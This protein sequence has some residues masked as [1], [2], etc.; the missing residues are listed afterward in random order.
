MPSLE[1]TLASANAEL[2]LLLDINRAIGR[3]LSRDELFGSLADRL[4]TI[5]PTDRFGIE[6]PIEGGK[7]QGHLLSRMPTNGEPTEP[8]V[9]PSTG[10]A[11]DWVI[12]N[13][14]WFVAD[15]RDELRDRFPITFDVMTSERMESLC[16]LPLISGGRALGAL[17]FMAASKSAYRHLR[18]EFLDQVSNQMAIAVE[19]MKSYEEIAALNRTIADGAARLRTILEINNAI[20]TKLTRDEVFRAI[21]AALAPLVPYDRIAL[22]LYDTATNSVCLVAYEGPLRTGYS[23]VGNVHDLD[24]SHVGWV[25]KEKRPLLR[26]DLEKEQQF[27]SEQR[28]LKNGFRSLCALP[29]VIRGRSIGAITVAS[30]AI[31]RSRTTAVQPS[32]DLPMVRWSFALRLGEPSSSKRFSTFHQAT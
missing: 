17:F 12:R 7:L 13:R 8:T 3:H 27:S 24:D 11:C 14:N 29:L 31:L 1:K 5:V 23:P 15:S 20:A 32:S 2:D 6:F 30:W 10:T 26:H 16:A 21:C 22:S 19:N 18:R 9:L 4:K 25:F 28:A